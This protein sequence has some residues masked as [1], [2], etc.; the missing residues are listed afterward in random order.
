MTWRDRTFNPL[1]S[2]L[3]FIGLAA[4]AALIMTG[5]AGV[6]WGLVEAVRMVF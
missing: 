3:C 5:M 2:I 6:L 1:K 4:A